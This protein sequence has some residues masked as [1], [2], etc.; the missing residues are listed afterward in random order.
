MTHDTLNLG[1]DMKNIKISFN[2]VNYSKE[3]KLIYEL[4]FKNQ[5]R[6]IS[7]LIVTKLKYIQGILENIL[8]FLMYEI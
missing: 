7:K 6:P 2:W 1:L 8:K 4:C 3:I 5:S